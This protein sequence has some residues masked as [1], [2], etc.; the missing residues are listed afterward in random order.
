MRRHSGAFG[1]NVGGVAPEIFETDADSA[2]DSWLTIG[3]TEG[4]SSNTL[5]IAGIDFNSWTIEN[6][7]TVEDGAVF[8]MDPATGPSGQV[9]VA[10]VTVP[11]GDWSATVNAQVCFKA[12]WSARCR[13]SHAM[14]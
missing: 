13:F 12:G 6:A 3:H 2:Y 5:G 9:V 14:Y 7:L 11:V 10:Q 1:Q 4:D 8:L